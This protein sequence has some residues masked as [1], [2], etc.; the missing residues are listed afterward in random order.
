MGS[1][2]E[3]IYKLLEG[4]LRLTHGN[5]QIIACAGTGMTEFISARVA[6]L[7]AK[8]MAKP[9]NMVAFAF[10]ERAAK[11]LKFRIRGKIRELVGHQP[12]IGDIYVGTIHSFCFEL[13]KEFVPGRDRGDLEMSFFWFTRLK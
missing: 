9:E 7:I 2:I 6:Y 4:D 1:Y 3:P 11:E 13:L 12:D 10:T 5:L 8:E